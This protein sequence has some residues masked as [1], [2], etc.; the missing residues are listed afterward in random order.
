[1]EDLASDLKE[2]FIGVLMKGAIF[3]IRAIL[4]DSVQ[5]LAN[6][7]QNPSRRA[8]LKKLSF[9]YTRQDLEDE[10]NERSNKYTQVGDYE[11]DGGEDWQKIINIEKEDASDDRFEPTTEIP[12]MTGDLYN[13]TVGHISLFDANFLTGNKDH[14]DGSAWMILRNFAATLIKIAIY[15]ASL[16]LLITLIIYGIQIVG[17][18]YTNPEE[19]AEYKNRL[20][21]FGRA[22]VTLVSS[23]VIMGLSIFG[24]ASFFTSVQSRNTYELPIRVNVE[25]AG[26]SFSTTYAGYIR[27]MS[28]NEDVSRWTE[29]AWYAFLY[30]VLA[31]VNLAI[32]LIMLGRMLLLWLLSIIG[33]IIAVLSIFNIESIISYR[34]WIV[35]YVITAL[36][37]TAFSFGYMLILN[38]I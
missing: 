19:E 3:V 29:K 32:M 14:N 8:G 33:P 20:E 22:V 13:V 7:F 35:F 9:M 4:G 31:W 6:M 5:I 26:Y 27:Y 17:N 16:I 12:V 36:I 34:E 2:N 11:K 1:M 10:S 21:S 15:I 24:S 30:I 18:S 25:G 23:I 37:Q 38:S 28:Q